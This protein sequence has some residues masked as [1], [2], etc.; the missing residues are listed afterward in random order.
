[1]KILR[2]TPTL[3][4]QLDI[5]PP[6]M[7]NSCM[8]K[9]LWLDLPGYQA[10]SDTADEKYVKTYICTVIKGGSLYFSDNHFTFNWKYGGW[11]VS[12]GKKRSRSFFLVVASGYYNKNPFFADIYFCKQHE[13]Q[14]GQNWA[15]LS[16]ILRLGFYSFMREPICSK[17][18][19]LPTF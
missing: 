3:I 19:N 13:A 6:I 10:M 2:Y 14:N 16:K 7:P 18:P 17:I 4:H 5:Q 9:Q 12:N 15:N 8:K 11:F 1:M